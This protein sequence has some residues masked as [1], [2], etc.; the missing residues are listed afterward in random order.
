M[1]NTEPQTVVIRI[2]DM[3]VAPDDAASRAH[4]LLEIG[5]PEEALPWAESAARRDARYDSVLVEAK[6]ALHGPGAPPPGTSH[7]FRE[8]LLLDDLLP[9]RQ[10]QAPRRARPAISTAL[11]RVLKAVLLASIAGAIGTATLK[12]RQH[13][14]ATRIADGF[15]ALDGHLKAGQL[16][17]CAS[18]L[19]QLA[20]HQASFSPPQRATYARADAILFRHFD[21]D[22]ARIPGRRPPSAPPA[23]TGWPL[24]LG[25]S[26][27]H[28]IPHQ[29]MGM[30]VD[31]IDD[32]FRAQMQ[33][34]VHLFRGNKA[35]VR[36]AVL[37][38]EL[39]EPTNPVTL[40]H[41]ARLLR[42]VGRLHDS[43]AFIEQLREVSPESP[44][45][46]AWEGKEVTTASP[47]TTYWM[48]RTAADRDKDPA[49]KLAHLKASL[50]AVAYHPTF[51]ADVVE[52]LH[53]SGQIEP[54]TALLRSLETR[55]GT[56]YDRLALLIGIHDKGLEVMCSGTPNYPA[57]GR[58]CAIGLRQAS[59]AHAADYAANLFAAFP[60]DASIALLSAEILFAENR[61][62]SELVETLE[63]WTTRRRRRSL[64]RE[65]R[66]HLYA[67]LALAYLSENRHKDAT[68][69][70]HRALRAVPAQPDAQAIIDRLERTPKRRRRASRRRRIRRIH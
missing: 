37:R 57:L 49:R 23:A 30:A 34:R 11:A 4:H 22:P 19:S 64:S 65:E 47:V 29:S 7:D 33:A 39:L 69:M 1:D 38:A 50:K 20:P 52:T 13:R 56:S 67:H 24:L 15:S 17:Q 28:W 21:A 61:F 70:A 63:R 55:P 3:I 60:D 51:V 46:A 5:R 32:P 9:P 54:A 10:A 14:V 35:L 16:D 2:Q 41:G 12:I 43:D 26:P 8:Q 31:E 59:P 62:P 45:I 25:M 36:K 40:F 6:A 44:W 27:S 18:I 68:T 58:R 53:L 66:G 48:H 42:A